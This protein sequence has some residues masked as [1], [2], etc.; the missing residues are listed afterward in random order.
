[1]TQDAMSHMQLACLPF[2]TLGSC[3][4]SICG[5]SVI[6]FRPVCTGR[7]GRHRSLHQTM[8]YPVTGQED[9]VAAMCPTE[10]RHKEGSF[11]VVSVFMHDDAQRA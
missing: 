3:K 9:Y 5:F 8:S 11:G 1:M 2:Q 6:V 7:H 10:F 4:A